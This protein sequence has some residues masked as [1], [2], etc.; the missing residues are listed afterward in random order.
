MSSHVGSRLIGRLIFQAF[1][2]IHPFAPKLTFAQ[3][4]PMSLAL[5]I[6][7]QLEQSPIAHW[8]VSVHTILSTFRGPYILGPNTMLPTLV[9]ASS[10]PPTP[11]DL[12]LRLEL[13]GQRGHGAL[14]DVYSAKLVPLRAGA[15]SLIAK[16][17]DMRSFAETRVDGYDSYT[18]SKAQRAVANE[19]RLFTGPLGSLQGKVVPRFEGLMGSIQQDGE[20]VWCAVYEDV[21]VELVPKEM[22]NPVIQYG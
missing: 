16:L 6:S 7:P 18:R 4:G 22:F 11:N 17:T 19:V 5:G 13:V 8:P 12:N 10:S 9:P 14:W 3:L 20:Q 15:R 21:G 2:L 1:H